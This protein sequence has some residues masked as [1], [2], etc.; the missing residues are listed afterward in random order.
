[1]TAPRRPDTA[2]PEMAAPSPA[3]P[4]G[5]A[6]RPSIGSERTAA[7][8]Y[9]GRS[10]SVVDSGKRGTNA[11]LFSAGAEGWGFYASVGSGLLVGWGVDRW[12]GTD[13]IFLV[14]GLVAGAALAFW[15]L[16]LY[17]KGGGS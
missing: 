16:W 17:L 13:P 10:S 8:E 12:L 14:V 9:R 15:K 6:C 1:M 4:L 7:G 3:Y 5:V 11:E 2:D